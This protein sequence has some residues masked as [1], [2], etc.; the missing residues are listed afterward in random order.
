MVLRVAQGLPRQ[1]LIT[2]VP[3]CPITNLLMPGSLTTHMG[4]GPIQTC[5]STCHDT[6][7]ILKLFL[8]STWS[9]LQ[10]AN[11]ICCCWF[12]S[13]LAC[14][15]KHV[16]LRSMTV[17]MYHNGGWSSGD[18]PV[19]EQVADFCGALLNTQ[20]QHELC[21]VQQIMY[22]L[23]TSRLAEDPGDWALFCQLYLMEVGLAA[24]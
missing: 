2:G 18:D 8:K 6:F 21:H 20:L 15:L 14:C 1:M 5:I 22:I 9:T 3:S 7:K 16:P 13:L 12:V 23:S 10:P 4:V 24:S 11:F 17:Q 19:C